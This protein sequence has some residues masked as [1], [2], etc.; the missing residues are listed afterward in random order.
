MYALHNVGMTD[1]KLLG[2]GVHG[3]MHAAAVLGW[4]AAFNLLQ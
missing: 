1:V 4:A 2:C 3:L